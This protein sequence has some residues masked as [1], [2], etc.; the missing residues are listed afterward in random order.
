MSNSSDAFLLLRARDVGLSSWA[1]VLT[2][3]VFSF[4]YMGFSYPAGVISDRLGRWPV[5]GVGWAIYAIVYVGFVFTGAAGVW[6]LMAM[7]GVSVAMTDG[8]GKALIADHAAKERRGAALGVFYMLSGLV[9]L[10]ASVTA[11]VLWDR[12]FPA[13]TFAVG[14]GFALLAAVLIPVLRSWAKE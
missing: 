11:G 7:Y 2:Y 4:I 6:P 8:V 9:T 13:A 10:G 1:V 5:M 12:V 3:A 14:A